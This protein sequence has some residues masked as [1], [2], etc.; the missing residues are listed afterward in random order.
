MSQED[1]QVADA[2]QDEEPT[3]F[4]KALDAAERVAD[5]AFR[6]GAFLYGLVLVALAV[7]GFIA[8]PA[9]WWVSVILIVYGVYLIFG[10]SWVIW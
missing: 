7:I 2:T 6:V 3:K 9:A 8:V 4:D 10:G 5:G 1:D